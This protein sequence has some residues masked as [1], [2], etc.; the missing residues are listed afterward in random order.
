VLC[1][2]F[3]DMAGRPKRSELSARLTSHSRLQAS[4]ALRLPSM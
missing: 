4:P 3:S 1:A 2:R